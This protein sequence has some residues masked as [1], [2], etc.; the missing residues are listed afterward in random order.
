[1]KK[2]RLTEG[3]R[4]PPEFV[5]FK[6]RRRRRVSI[7]Q[8]YIGG[9]PPAEGVRVPPEFVFFTRRRRRSVSIYQSYCRRQEKNTTGWSGVGDKALAFKPTGR[10]S[11]PR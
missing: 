5:F 7:Y 10:G 6:R 3:V 2:K 1:M 8:S 4:V 11:A 9:L